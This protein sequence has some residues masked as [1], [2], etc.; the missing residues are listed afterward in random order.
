MEKEKPKKSKLY[1]FIGIV[2]GIIL[3]K[4]IFEFV[5]PMLF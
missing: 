5:W 1:F 3:Y 4:I 2:T